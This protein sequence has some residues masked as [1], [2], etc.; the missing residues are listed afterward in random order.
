MKKTVYSI[1]VAT[2]VCL[3]S[4]GYN[5]DDVWNAINN[6]E[7]R[8]TA[9]ENWQKT[10]NE[11]IA[12]L[13]ALVNEND[14]ITDVTP[15]VENGETTGYII[16][17][18]KQ[19]SI[20]IYN[21]AKGDK[22]ETG[23]TP[24]IGVTKQEDGK[25]YW[26]LN[27]ELLKDAEG[28]PICASGQ[29]GED[30]EDGSDGSNGS[31]GTSAPTPLVEIGK[32]LSVT[33]DKY[34]NSIITDAIY[35]SV[36]GGKTWVK[37]SGDNGSSGTGT[38]G[39]IINVVDKND[40]YLFECADGTKIEI[41]IYKGLRL[42][43]LEKDENENWKEK[44]ITNGEVKA[45][46][47]KNFVIQC[48]YLKGYK[49]SYD[50]VKGKTN[51][52]IERQDYE[53]NS[54]IITDLKFLGVDKADPTTILFSLVSEDNSVEHY[55][56]VITVTEDD[57]ATVDVIPGTANNTGLVSALADLGI[58]TKDNEGNLNLT[59][60][61][62]DETTSLNLNAK[63]LTSLEGLDCF[64]N[65]TSLDCSQNQ[66][67][68]IDCSRFS[69]LTDF[70]CSNN[71]LTALDLT[72][73]TELE[74]LYCSNNNLSNLD[75][76][77]NPKL[78]TLDCN[79]NN[80]P[81]LDIS[82]LRELTYLDC[83]GCFSEPSRSLYS[84]GTIDL[85]NH[86]NLEYLYCNEN[87]LQTLDVTQTPKLKT[88]SCDMNNLTKLDLSNNPNLEILFCNNNK[89]QTLDITQNLN[90]ESFSC[91]D[92]NLTELKL[93]NN[94][95]LSRLNC[96]DNRLKELDLS[97]YELLYEFYANRNEITHLIL[98][99][100]SLLRIIGI[101]SNSISDINVSTYMD[102]IELDCSINNLKSLDVSHNPE[103]NWLACDENQM[104]TLNISHN[105]KMNSLRCGNQHKAD[106]TEQLLVL[107]VNEEQVSLWENIWQYYSNN[108]T[109]SDQVIDKFGGNSNDF[110]NGG[111]Y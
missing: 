7:E 64:V 25:Y 60:R 61:D 13:Q 27:G 81:T 11:N 16:S 69:K 79:D 87:N 71:S 53:D 63:Q 36:D 93:G 31:S 41:P 10:I 76:S 62:I 70:N 15:I 96:C 17:F 48:Y 50:I 98:P 78:K 110:T 99:E 104:Y 108:V 55:Q 43:Y 80:L 103:L 75:V 56:I 2:M 4:C 8:I 37:V 46:A 6:Q 42:L 91:Y 72:N 35:L 95:K 39:F 14:Y 49:M 5:D 20:T 24:S 100:K 85:S 21:G 94:T 73:L 89:L 111:V 18:F 32:N 102:L 66:L 22:G 29:D 1:A 97:Q 84:N 23:D 65:L 67:T 101:S 90:L 28:N 82:T 86:P 3:A 44:N 9:L 54:P 52:E 38:E 51:W 12:A 58:G 88:L 107:T 47:K 19:G 45:T 92:N 77:N 68:E 74:F 59:Q 109:I 33:A 26:T 106:G 57:G 30:G 83:S 105:D 34:G 40:Y